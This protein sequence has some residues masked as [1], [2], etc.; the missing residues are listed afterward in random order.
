M[1]VYA[2]AVLCA[3][4]MAAG[5]ILFKISSALHAQSGTFFSMKTA[6]AFLTAMLLYG[7]IS[8][9]WVWVLQK[10]ELGRVYPIM[11]MA[12]ILVPIASHFFFGERFTPQ[13]F[14]GVMFIMFGIYIT[15]KS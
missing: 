10:S 11:A 5:Q 13:Y 15:V 9:V 2:A 8:I 1:N 14:I 4:G 3:V 7:V 12:F 6:A